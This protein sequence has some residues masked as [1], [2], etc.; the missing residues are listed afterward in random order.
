MKAVQVQ[1]QPL[2]TLKISGLRSQQGAVCVALFASAEGFPND[3]AQAV[4][5]EYFPISEIPLTITFSDVPFGRYAVSIF[6]DENSDGELNLGAFGIPQEGLGFSEN[7]QLWKGPPKFQQTD[8]EFTSANS[9]VE[10]TMK[11]F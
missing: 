1:E 11:Y 8:F 9:V 7:P 5:A 2:I 10:I 3:S 4:K 6:H